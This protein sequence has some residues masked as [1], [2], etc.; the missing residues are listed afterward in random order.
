MSKQTDLSLTSKQIE[1]VYRYT[2]DIF[3]ALPPKAIDELMGGY[4]Q[5]QEALIDEMLRQVT[6]VVNFGATLESEKLSY[7]DSLEDSMDK[8]LRKLSYNYFKTTVLGNTFNQGWRNLDWGNLVQLYPWSLFLASRGHGKCE[9]PETEVVMFDGTLKQIKDIVVGDLVMGVDSTPRT[10]LFAHKGVDDMYEVVQNRTENYKV[11]SQHLIYFKNKNRGKNQ[12]E[13]LSSED[14]HKKSNKFKEYSFGVRVKGWET[15][16]K[17]LKLEPYFLGVWISDGRASDQ[18]IINPDTEIIDYL[19]SLCERNGLR[20][21]S[22]DNNMRHNIS[23]IKGGRE[24]SI[25]RGLRE[26]NLIGNKH[27]P[28]EY[29]IGSKEQRLELLAG[30]IDG[31]GTINSSR[32]SYV[33]SQINLDLI[34]QVQRLCWSLGYKANISSTIASNNFSKGKDFITYNLGI[35]GDVWEI[36]VKVKRKKVDFFQRKTDYQQSSLK[37]NYLGKGEYCGIT[38][39]RDHLYLGKDGTIKHNSFEF[40]FAFLLW[41]LYSYDRPSYYEKDTLDNRNRK[42]TLLI[43]NESSLGI[44]HLSKV[45]EE[46]NA[47][48]ILKEKLNPRG[49]EL[50]K[51]GFSTE[52]GSLI[53]LRSLFSSGTRGNHCGSVVYD[54]LLDESSLYSK[55]QRAKA[56]EI[57][58]GAITPVVEPG[59]F[60]IGSGTPYVDAEG[61][62]YTRLKKDPKHRVWEYPAIVPIMSGNKIIDYRLLAPDRFTYSDLISV[63]ESI[64]SSVFSREY[65]VSPV[66]D[67]SSIFPYEILNKCIFGMENIGFAQN[68][69]SYPFKLTRVVAG[70]DFAI[71]GN[72]GADSTVMSVW[73]IDSNEMYYLLYIWRKSGATHNEQ[74]NQIVAI[75]RQFKPNA[76]I[77]EANGF[78]G[79]LADMAEQR[80]LRNIE[81]FI[82]TGFNKKNSYEGLPSLAAIME[83]GQL[84]VPYKEGETRDMINLW[85]GEFNSIAFNSDSGKLE[86]VGSHDDLCMSTFFAVQSLRTKTLKFKAHLL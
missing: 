3:N 12:I 60:L 52:T 9:S 18:R 40:A 25:K 5:D 57:F 69:D 64:G 19:K 42:E 23:Y 44:T 68:I 82:T 53:K 62:L 59:G 11:N 27:I 24:N 32:R 63:K 61:D 22:H 7:L 35:S 54:D 2:Q 14:F 21:T 66:T 36:P 51:T 43:T 13:T 31:D 46:I 47:N 1:Q 29:L 41:R 83:R 49:R 76:I 84:R 79:I 85:M 15:K 86:G 73:G 26:L 55:E 80:G 71:S 75:D 38:L 28:E 56:V 77:C 16:E 33:F 39:D 78:Q 8:V 10:V 58:N 70:I 74:I 6:N 67:D 20:L 45:I 17:E 72:I 48:E 37:T 34:K 65:L 81:P 30:L 50:G 4:K